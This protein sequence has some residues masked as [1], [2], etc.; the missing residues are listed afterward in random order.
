VSSAEAAANDT[1][2]YYFLRGCLRHFD[3]PF[4]P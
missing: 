3:L 1:D 4:F 2:L